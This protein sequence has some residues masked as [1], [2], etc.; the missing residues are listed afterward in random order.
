MRILTTILRDL[1]GILGLSSIT[2]ACYLVDLR[3]GLCVGGVFCVAISIM[4]GLEK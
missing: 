2:F 3:L 4:T 1:T